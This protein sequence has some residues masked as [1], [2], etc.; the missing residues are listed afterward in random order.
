MITLRHLSLWSSLRPKRSRFKE[1]SA[2]W[3]ALGFSIRLR[4]TRTASPTQRVQT[5]ESRCGLIEDVRAGFGGRDTCH[6]KPNALLVTGRWIRTRK[7][8]PIAPTVGILTWRAQSVGVSWSLRPTS[9]R[10]ADGT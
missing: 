6:R 5:G 2:L 10:D 7:T 1:S 9:V 3:R 4:R 8:R